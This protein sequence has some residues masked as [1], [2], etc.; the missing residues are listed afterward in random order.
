MT[1]HSRSPGRGVPWSV[2]RL[3]LAFALAVAAACTTTSR[4][5]GAQKD[6]PAAGGP[7][8]A[9]GSGPSSAGTQAVGRG[10]TS[11]VTGDAS[12]GEAGGGD[13]NDNTPV[14][15]GTDG[16]DGGVGTDTPT[17]G[18]A[19]PEPTQTGGRANTTGGDGGQGGDAS[20]ICAQAKDKY[21]S[22]DVDT[23]DIEVDPCDS[24]DVCSSE[25]VLAASCEELQYFDITSDFFYCFSLCLSA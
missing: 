7:T 14:G 17:G 13:G 19:G 1:I 2:E 22:C 4:A 11:G 8:A 3:S 10:G 5:P 23:S 18:G 16:G 20:N 9:G 21:E 12:S 24:T 25:C 15:T 6:E